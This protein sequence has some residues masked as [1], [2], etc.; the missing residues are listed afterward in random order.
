MT[1][2]EYLDKWEQDNTPL[3]SVLKNQ[4]SN[5]DSIPEKFRRQ[6]GNVN[7]Q[8]P[9]NIFKLTKS[10]GKTRAWF[11]DVVKHGRH[12]PSA[13]ALRALTVAL[14]WPEELREAFMIYDQR[15]RETRRENRLERYQKNQLYR[16]GL[17]WTCDKC[18]QV[19]YPDLE[20][21]SKKQLIQFLRAHVLKKST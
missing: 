11:Y 3:L 7:G 17:T 10:I 19:V 21:L 5:R 18:N 14:E 6:S 15:Y 8:F 4:L 20:E 12:H 16:A 1:V 2:Q 9:I 13:G